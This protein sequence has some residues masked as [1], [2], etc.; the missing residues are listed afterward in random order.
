VLNGLIPGRRYQVQIWVADDRSWPGLVPPFSSSAQTVR[1]SA[2][3]TDIPT[4][5]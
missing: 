4:L 3:D 2:A 5:R 1:G